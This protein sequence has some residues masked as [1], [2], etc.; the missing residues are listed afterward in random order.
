MDDFTSFWVH[1]Y[2]I[3]DA[4]QEAEVDRLTA[5]DVYQWLREICSSSLIYRPQIVLGGPGVV[6]QIDE[7]VFCHKPKVCAA[8]WM[9]IH[10][11]TY[12]GRAT[13][14]ELWDFGMADTSVTPAMGYIEVV[15]RHDAATLLPIINTHTAPGNIIHSDMWA[16][17]NRVQHLPPVAAHN[18]VNHFVDPVTGV[19]TQNIE[20]Y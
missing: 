17:Y 1:Q 11:L 8:A 16:S 10:L 19:H 5:I 2:P 6:V 20:S 7:S 4:M 14:Q 15:Q 9:S 13:T 3:T 12:R 18:T